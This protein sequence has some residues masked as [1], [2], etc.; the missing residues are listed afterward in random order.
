MDTPTPTRD[1]SASKIYEAISR[2]SQISKCL[3]ELQ[4]TRSVSTCY[5]VLPHCW[6]KFT[7]SRPRIRT[8]PFGCGR[9]DF[10]M[11]DHAF[12]NHRIS[13]FACVSHTNGQGN[14]PRR[15][16]LFR[17]DRSATAALTASGLDTETRGLWTQ[18][19]ESTRHNA[20]TCSVLKT[21]FNAVRTL[22]LERQYR[23]DCSYNMDESDFPSFE[24]KYLFASFWLRYLVFD[25]P[26]GYLG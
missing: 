24:L 5:S 25:L 17:Y 19:I 1:C 13:C 9:E 6:T 4:R 11:M 15:H 7:I 14:A 16:R 20:T 2:T 18:Q 26:V 23:P 8:D 12:N 3:Y 21:W 10:S 22:R